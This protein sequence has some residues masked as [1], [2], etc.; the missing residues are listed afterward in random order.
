MAETLDAP[1]YL[2]HVARRWRVIA[3]AATVAFALALGG[4]L[5][6]P[7]QYTARARLVIDPPPA[8]DGRAVMAVSPIYLESLRTYE[9]FATSDRL[10]QRALEHFRLRAAAS[11]RSIESWKRGVLKVEVPRNTKILEIRVKLPDPNKAQAMAQYLA[12]ETVKLNRDLNQA[13]DRELAQE[14]GAQ[15]DQTRRQ[16]DQAAAAWRA[17]AR[18]PVEAVEASIQSL[19]SRRFQAERD[20]LAAESRVAGSAGAPRAASESD[21]S[22]AAFLRQQLQTI[23]Q[24][25]SRQTALLAA[26]SARQD[27][28]AARRRSAQTALDN[29]QRRLEEA[30]ASSGYR[31]ER[32]RLIDPG[33][34]PER[35]SSPNIPLNLLV[36]VLFAI[37]SAVIV[38]LV[39]AG[40]RE[41]RAAPSAPP[42]LRVAGRGRDD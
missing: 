1:Q 33:I 10:F 34:V 37:V 36:A 4:S 21:R 20:L 3:I 39:E 7:A 2:L 32:L 35:P 11:G 13:G 42:A 28:V 18:E 22:R 30:R 12:E 14:L 24:E 40:Y 16:V 8:S 41:R 25:M 19:K 31:G 23:D 15:L 6:M 29:V 5:L 9:H 27:E 17:L 38:L 26:R